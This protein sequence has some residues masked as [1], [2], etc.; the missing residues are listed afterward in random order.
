MNLC[1]IVVEYN[2]FHNGHIHHIKEA[3][4]LTNP[5]AIIAIMSGNY[6]ERG[7]LSVMDK[8]AKA[9]T[10]L[11]NGIDLVIELPFV[12]ATQSASVFAKG[13]VEILNKCQINS[14]CFGSETNDLEGL[15]EVASVEI[16]PDNLKEIMKEGL[17]YPKAISLLSDSFYPNDI[18][19]I[20][21]LK[22]LRDKDIKPVS[23]AR[24]N[25]Y[26]SSELNEIASASAI[27][28][29]IKEGLDYHHATPSNIPYPVFIEDLYPYLRRIL[30]TASREYLK[31]IHMVSEGIEKVLI[32]NAYKY[33]EY[34]D[35]ISHCTSRRYTQS[36]IQRILLKIM[37]GIK[38]NDLEN[39]D[40]NYIRVL[41]F[42]DKG[43]EVIK[44]LKSKDID[45]ITQF[46]KLPPKAKEIE[47]KATALYASLFDEKRY[48]YLL[49]RELKGPEIKTEVM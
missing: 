10:A 35:F 11:D 2:P 31:E 18:L 40:F 32:D 44:Y 14:L 45:V 7:D 34:N 43:R 28:K 23:I 12:Y 27:R 17:S 49:N 30:L 24:T 20:S 5:D 1:G 13:A 9:K 16:N 21:Y 19:A 48:E 15:M 36:R 33:T 38:K 25:H 4:R 46:K 26:H 8:F 37:L 42:N 29:A 47:Y 41:G 22:A 39:T 3:R 6:T